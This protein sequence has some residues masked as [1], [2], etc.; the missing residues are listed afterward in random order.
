MS[1]RVLCLYTCI[2]PD[3]HIFVYTPPHTHLY[4]IYVCIQLFL[5][6]FYLSK[7]YGL[8]LASPWPVAV[9]MLVV[10]VRRPVSHFAE[11]CACTGEQGPCDVP[12]RGPGDTDACVSLAC[13]RFSM[14]L[15]AKE[16]LFGTH[17]ILSCLKKHLK[18][19]IGPISQ[20]KIVFITKTTFLLAISL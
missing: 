6:L 13:L 1:I 19:R 16:K 11:N 14:Q 15:V 12:T 9:A 8:K 18:K 10:S 20:K 7:I 17:Y 4:T 3:I 5:T 2:H